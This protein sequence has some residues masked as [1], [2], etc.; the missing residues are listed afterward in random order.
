MLLTLDADVFCPDPKMLLTLD[1]DVF[2]P[3]PK[4]KIFPREAEKLSD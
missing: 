1:A 2:C 4:M 3:D